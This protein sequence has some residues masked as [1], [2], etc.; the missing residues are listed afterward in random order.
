METP[1][2]FSIDEFNELLGEQRKLKSLAGIACLRDERIRNELDQYPSY[3]CEQ[4]GVDYKGSKD[5]Q[6]ACDNGKSYAVMQWLFERDLDND[7]VIFV[8][9]IITIYILPTEI[10]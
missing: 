3:F 8:S 7:R 10:N 9:D 5:Y 4:L 2:E 6:Q 1:Y